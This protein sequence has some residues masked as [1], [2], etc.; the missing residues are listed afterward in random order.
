MKTLQGTLARAWPKL[1][2]FDPGQLAGKALRSQASV[3][4]TNTMRPSGTVRDGLV[5]QALR[6]RECQAAA[7][8]DDGPMPVA[9]DSPVKVVP[10]SG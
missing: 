8:V 2:R 5:E 4:L 6:S 9:M 3:Q 1:L 10:T 7:G